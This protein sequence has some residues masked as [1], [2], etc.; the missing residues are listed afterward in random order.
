[1]RVE[2]KKEAGRRKKGVDL[3]PPSYL[4]L[5]RGREVGWL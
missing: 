5:P 3:L 4:L 1:M 2:R